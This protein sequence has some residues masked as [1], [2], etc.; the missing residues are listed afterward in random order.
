MIDYYKLQ[1]LSDKVKAN[2]ATQAE[3]DEYMQMLFQNG[4]ITQNQYDKYNKEKN[5]S[6]TINAAI[7]IGGIILFGYLLDKLISGDKN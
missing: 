6:E 1:Q 5:N 2:T 3:K 7:T 4:S